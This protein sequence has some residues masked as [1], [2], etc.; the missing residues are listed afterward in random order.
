MKV[1]QKLEV[2]RPP[3]LAGH[4]I[5][6]IRWAS[7]LLTDRQTDRQ[8]A[9]AGG[10]IRARAVA[11]RINFSRDVAPGSE[12]LKPPLIQF[13]GQIPER[14]SR[15]GWPGLL[16]RNFLMEVEAWFN[17]RVWQALTLRD[18]LRTVPGCNWSFYTAVF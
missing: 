16:G 2:L 4:N 8:A 7:S 14:R 17:G 6:C 11:P 10:E 5:P 9:K 18:E 3:S 15:Y 13:P 1:V 12:P